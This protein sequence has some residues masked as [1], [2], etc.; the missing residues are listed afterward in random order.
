MNLTTPTQIRSLPHTL[1]FGIGLLLGIGLV[2]A[3]GVEIPAVVILIVV[4]L[5]FFLYGD[6]SGGNPTN[7]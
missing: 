7:E 4:F 1:A 6:F 2:L 5:G 3:S